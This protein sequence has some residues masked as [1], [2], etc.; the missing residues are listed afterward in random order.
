M[1]KLSFLRYKKNTC[2]IFDYILRL[3]CKDLQHMIFLRHSFN[4]MTANGKTWVYV[5]LGIG[6]RVPWRNLDHRGNVS[7][8]KF[9]FQLILS[10]NIGCIV[11][12][13]DLCRYC[14]R[15]IQMFYNS[16]MPII[17]VFSSSVRISESL[18]KSHSFFLLVRM[19]WFDKYSMVLQ[20]AH[21]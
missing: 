3:I 16:M 19:G 17:F 1:E 21:L 11:M 12:H 13:R 7:A 4:S 14:D 8:L 15:Q 18:S 5:Y 10:G 2:N 9:W 20:K 6:F